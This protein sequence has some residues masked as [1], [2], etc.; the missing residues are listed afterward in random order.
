MFVYSIKSVISADFLVKD[1]PKLFQSDFVI[2]VI[3]FHGFRVK[4]VFVSEIANVVE[5]DHLWWLA[6]YFL[7]LP[8]LASKRN[9]LGGLA[10]VNVVQ[11]LHMADLFWLLRCIPLMTTV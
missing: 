4:T 9:D 10:P 3:G 1:F 8:S 11:I 6:G 7:T 2:D 5:S